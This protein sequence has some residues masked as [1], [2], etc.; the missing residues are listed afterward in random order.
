[1]KKILKKIAIISCAALIAVSSA[2]CTGGEKE[3]VNAYDIAVKN[4]FVGTEQEWLQSLK[5]ENGQDA[6]DITIQ[7]AYEAAQANGF[8]GSRAYQKIEENNGI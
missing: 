6:A 4:G 7:D 5:G 1:M 8:Q 3:I 2:A